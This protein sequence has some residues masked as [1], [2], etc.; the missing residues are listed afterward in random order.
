V[1]VQVYETVPEL[2]PLGVGINLLPHSVR[3]LDQLGALVPLLPISVQI[4]EQILFTRRGQQVWS[5]PRG[6]A[7]GYRWSQLAIH[8]GELQMALLR[9]V[10]ETLPDGAVATGHHLARWQQ[11]DAGV[12][13]WLV[14]RRTGTPLVKDQADVLVAADGMH[15]TVRAALYPA[16]GA[17]VWNGAM[18]YRG[19]SDTAPFLSGRTQVMVGGEQTFIAYPIRLTHG[20]ALTNWAARFFV[21]TDQ[22]FARE[23][24]NRAGDA[25]S[26]LQ[27]YAS[28][29]FDWLDVPSVIAGADA[30]YEYPMV[31]RDPLP[32]W[33]FG[34]VTLLGD[35]AHPMYPLGSNGASQAILDAV[36]LGEALKGARDA[37]AAL[38]AYD[39]ARR[40]ATAEVVTMN[41]AGGP[42]VVVRMVEE[43]APD[44]FEDLESVMPYEE[45]AAIAARYKRAAGF[46]V[47]NVNA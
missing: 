10:Q 44:G 20:R 38:T 8:R 19:T 22:G 3:M 18:I 28:W 39:A 17:P 27:R 4:A 45:R 14:D 26:F 30:V 46:D 37:E 7:A 42:E 24:W 6:R 23:E 31:D 35:A 29:R 40:A 2:Q 16:E 12:I 36:A 25:S 1:D 47:T 32:R 9:T 11:G 15:S 21:P 41:R 33:S 5:E 43:R 34:R 13:A